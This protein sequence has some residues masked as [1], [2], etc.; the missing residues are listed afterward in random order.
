LRRN[1][2]KTTVPIVH[3]AAEAQLAAIEAA[4]QAMSESSPV[5][6]PEMEAAFKRWGI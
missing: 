5:V 4:E 2:W 3:E 6:N 1:G